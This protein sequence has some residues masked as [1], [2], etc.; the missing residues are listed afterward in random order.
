MLEPRR[1]AARQ[2]AVRAANLIDEE[3]GQTV[4]YRVRLESRVS[5]GTRLEVITE[6]IL[7]AMLVDDPTLDGVD[8]VIFDEFHERSLNSDEALA[9][10]LEA[11]RVL[12]PDLRI[13][14]MSAT[15]DSE[16]ICRHIGGRTVI[17]DGKM[18]P[19]ELRRAPEADAG[20]V[21]ERVAD[22]VR[23]AFRDESGSILAFLPG[24]A[25][26]RRC[27][28]LLEGLSEAADIFPLYG[29]LPFEEQKR[30]IAPAP[31]GRRKIVLATSIAE[32]SLTIEGVRCVVDCGL[33]RKQFYDG[34]SG[35][36]RLETVRISQDMARQRAG[37][38][39]RT[40]PGVC[41]RLWSA[42][43]E[44][45][46]AAARMPEIL[47]ADLA[48]L[49]LDLAAWGTGD[50]CR[51]PWLTPPPADAFRDATALLRSLGALDDGM[52]ITS[53]G[54]K[55]AS[56]PC[57]P[58]IANM[59]INA[60][61]PDS[62]ALAADIA[63]ILDGRD[64]MPAAGADINIRI[65]GLRRN[66][67]ARSGIW[68]GLE[69]AAAQYRRLAGHHQGIVERFDPFETGRL[70]SYAYPERIAR[71]MDGTA[72]VYRLAE[73]SQ[74]GVDGDDPL[75]AYD[76]LAAASLTSVK[77]GKGH[78]FLASPVSPDSLDHLVRERDNIAWDG[79][80]GAVT[81]CHERNIGCLCV[82]STQIHSGNRDRIERCICE[83]ARKEGLSML[84]FS[85]EVGN[86]QRR[87][88]SAAAWHPELG[89]PDLSTERLLATAPDW[90]PAFIGN[91][92]SVTQLKR[93]DLCQVIWSLLDYTSQQTVDRLAPSHIEVP[94]GS[95]I[96]LEYR[97]GADAP[98]LRVRLQ[99]CFGLLDTPA[100][101]D[102]KRPVLMELLSPGFKP[103]QLTSDLASF[104]RGT[105]FEVRKELRRRYPKHS[106]P[107]NPLSAAPVRGVKKR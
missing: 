103:V 86:L 45:R 4:G 60:G 71:A 47:E 19:V 24:E 89:L 90:L 53:Q 54:R 74:A 94:T 99:E 95:R 30:A 51:L 106:W 105:Y 44:A 92:T 29:M 65:D 1:L 67:K 62:L 87:I 79:R 88:A 68:A 70:L 55:M 8:T 56:L 76:W 104:W 13:V 40:E 82:S 22:A 5:A 38:A 27:Q 102:G 18:F 50:A 43:T 61:C 12:R 63:A 101:D 15:M 58:R 28:G 77:G 39:G 6:G 10:V 85:D 52:G 72:A 96:R 66:R 91:A 17:A 2:I 75:S 14:V 7:T 9:L 26:I 107:D 59:I 35:L 34:R 33:C 78:I 16:G 97:T 42:A 83:A 46:M 20:N 69:A 21:A 98:V 11:R 37:R 100:V 23:K 80:K 57:H 3:V 36:S 93:I 25:D 73:G 49:A 81:A 48:G 84:D 64:P 41:I 32:T 31:A